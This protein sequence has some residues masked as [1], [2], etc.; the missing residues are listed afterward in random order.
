M[1]TYTSRNR[2]AAVPQLTV[3]PLWC[4]AASVSSRAYPRGQYAYE[5]MYPAK[6]V[7]VTSIHKVLDQMASTCQVLARIAYILLHVALS[8][9]SG[10]IWPLWSIYTAILRSICV[11]DVE[12]VL[13]R[14][15]WYRA[16][17]TIAHHTTYRVPVPYICLLYTSPSPRD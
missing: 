14:R 9:A 1:C 4:S 8:S 5:C 2:T 3:C 13:Y 6:P 12:K 16:S 17:L 7:R 10:S 15:T 11:R